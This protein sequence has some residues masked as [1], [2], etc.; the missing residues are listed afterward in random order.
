[1]AS[2]SPK[3]KVKVK[4][5]WL[6][7]FSLDYGKVLSFFC[8][9]EKGRNLVSMILDF[10]I[11]IWAWQWEILILYL[12]SSVWYLTQTSPL[13]VYLGRKSRSSI[14]ISFR[15]LAAAFRAYNF[16]INGRR[17]FQIYTFCVK[18]KRNIP[19]SWH[20]VLTFE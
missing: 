18:K 16:R 9:W 2:P 8:F 20:F 1:M 12:N 15:Q 5:T 7:L 6:T 11:L 4:R 19:Q 13:S 14:N 3:C 17:S 10:E